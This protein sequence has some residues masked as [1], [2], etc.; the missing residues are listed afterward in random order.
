MEKIIC[1]KMGSS[2]ILALMA[3]SLTACGGGDQI[4]FPGA[5]APSASAVTAPAM[6]VTPQSNLNQ[7]GNV[8]VAK[9]NAIQNNYQSNLKVSK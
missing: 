2:L 1:T 6:S 7:N 9:F 5:N 3:L 8:D 4:K